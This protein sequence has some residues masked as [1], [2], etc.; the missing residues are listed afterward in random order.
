MNRVAALLVADD[1][2][3]VCYHRGEDRIVREWPLSGSG[4]WESRATGVAPAR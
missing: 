4:N 2:R 3:L 1:D